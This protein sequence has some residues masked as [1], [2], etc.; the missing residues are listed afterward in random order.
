MSLA[1]SV[2]CMP[3]VR[4]CTIG[5]HTGIQG[6]CS[7][8]WPLLLTLAPTTTCVST[9][10][11]ATIQAPAAGSRSCVHIITLAIATTFPGPYPLDLEAPLKTLTALVAIETPYSTC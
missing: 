6:P 2:G 4:P 8:L 9:A 10:T 7:W 5:V 1:S 3:K 11:P